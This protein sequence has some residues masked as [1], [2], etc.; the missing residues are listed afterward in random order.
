MNHRAGLAFL[1]LFCFLSLLTKEFL[2]LP[3]GRL[4]VYILDVGQGDSI[5]LI[6]PSGKQILVDG[7]PDLSPLEGMARHMSFFDRTVDLLVLSHPDL[8]HIAAMSDIVER[9][10]IGA[11]LIAGIETPQPQYRRLLTLIA[12][13]NVPVLIAD[14]A[15]DIVFE[16]G[17]ILDVVWPHNAFAAQPKKMNDV[18][19]VVR[20]LHKEESILLTGD[21]EKRAEEGI[22]QTGVDV[23]SNVLKIAHH[24]SNTSTSTGFLLAVNPALAIISVGK[25]NPFGHPHREVLQRLR[26]AGIG[27]R[28]TDQ[29][30][31]ISFLLP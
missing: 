9:Y 3:D 12:K 15:K 27:V 2:T 26:N 21:I 6:S 20:A 11:I 25:G 24:G 16:D 18:S 30:G 31:E 23:R 5:F 13:K 10:D 14:P 17:L 22:L 4:H 8:D 7:G 1:G 29:E 28:R 19:V